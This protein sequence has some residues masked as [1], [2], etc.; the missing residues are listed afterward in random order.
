[1]NA[2]EKIVYS[3][4]EKKNGNGQGTEIVFFKEQAKHIHR[5]G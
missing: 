5:V 2:D 1:M 3:V 4:S